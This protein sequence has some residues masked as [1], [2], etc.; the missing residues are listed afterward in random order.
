MPVLPNNTDPLK[1]YVTQGSNPALTQ[2]GLVYNKIYAH[3]GVVDSL[4]NTNKNGYADPILGI[5]NDP[6]NIISFDPNLQTEWFSSQNYGASDGSSTPITLMYSLS[7]TTYFNQISFQLLNV[8]CYVELLADGVVLSGTSTFI[9][10]GGQD[11]YTTT[12]WIRINYQGFN[13]AES[14]IT[15]RI[16]RNKPV[17]SISDNGLPVNIAYSVGVRNFSLKL[18]VKALSDITT[19]TGQTIISQNRF[20][21]VENYNYTTNPISNA[22]VNDNTYWKSGPQ[23]TKDSI[24]YF[25]A[26]I[27]GG[28]SATINRIYLDPLY[29]GCKFNLYFTTAASGSNLDQA[30]WFPVQRD[31]S[32]RK[33]IYEIPNITGTHLKFEFVQL[34]AESYDLPFDSVDRTIN[35]F[36]YDV[37]SYYKNLEQDIMLGNA[38]Q[39]Q[40]NGDQTTNGPSIGSYISSSTMFGIGNTAAAASSF[41]SLTNL[42]YSQYGNSTTVAMTSQSYVVD[43]TISYKLIN[44]D[45]S[46]NNQEY[47]D[48]L[49]RRFP[50]AGQHVY[51]QITVKQNWHQ[52]YFV[53]IRYANVFYENTYD[54]L[55]G[56]PNNLTVTNGVTSND[57]VSLATNGT[58]I[59]PWFNTVDS[60]NSFSIAG[61]TSDWR[62][63]LSDYQALGGAWVLYSGAGSTTAFNNGNL[64]TSQIILVSG[65][66]T[67]PIS[68]YGLISTAY[69]SSAN[70]I[71]YY[72]ANFI[73]VSGSLNWVSGSGTTIASTSVTYSGSTI[74]GLSV[75]GGSYTA[76]YNFTLPNVIPSG[77]QT[78]EFDLGGSPFGGTGF[79]SYNPVSGFNYYFLVNSQVSGIANVPQVNGTLTFSTSFINPATNTAI[80]GTT[81][82]GTVATF[83]SGTGS[84]VAT[85]TGTNYSLGI[86]SNIIQL[87]VNGSGFPYNLFQLAA[88]TSPVTVWSSPLVANNLRISGVARIFLPGGVNKGTYVCSLNAKDT[89]GNT[90][91]LTSKTYLPGSIPGGTWMDIELNYFNMAN[92]SNFFVQ[93]I[94]TNTSINETFYVSLLSPF[95]HPVRYEYITVSGATNWQ[96][97]TTGVNNSTS[98]IS[99]V[100]GVTASG[101]QIRMTSADHDV[102]ICGVSVVPYYKNNPY[103]AS[104]DMNYVGNSKT[105][106]LSSRRPVS[107]KPYFLLNKESHPSRFNIDQIAG[108][109]L[110]YSLD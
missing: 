62:S 21:F 100:S 106:E 59:T 18:N 26:A 66:Q 47:S 37:E 32:L 96:P 99:T 61:L 56:T 54:D 52:A 69:N 9:V 1:D 19:I 81:V 80:T 10:G 38:V 35:I 27:S 91:Q 16:T 103:Y 94:Q 43:P 5:V 31:F 76:T 48:F 49:Q 102:Y 104:L 39:Y 78:W 3:T 89:G 45:G 12:D 107:Q 90:I 57:Y 64:G 83:A 60:F 2:D 68:P 58:A 82:T 73:P 86:P 15:L 85:L 55:R 25:Y 70:L 101:I 74:S 30:T 14:S 72:D 97:I 34:Y 22:F 13:T 28:A 36:P 4:S 44:T 29:S 98:L 84:N 24:V 63:F 8:P 109:V 88:N 75:S 42:N 71:G 23:P 110:P 50:N 46:Y 7:N 77:A 92:Y 11:I 108:T 105:N 87:S 40:P 41:P 33:G 53:G 51:S 20:G 93:I 67:P 79:A 65:T 95:Y 17:Q 6:N